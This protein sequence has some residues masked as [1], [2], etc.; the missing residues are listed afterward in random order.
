MEIR[1]GDNARKVKKENK[2]KKTHHFYNIF[3]MGR[4]SEDKISKEN[5]K[6]DKKMVKKEEPPPQKRFSFLLF[7]FPPCFAF[8]SIFNSFSIIHFRDSCF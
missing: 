2:T 5:P 3:L 8:N 6:R 4:T 7:C 1:E